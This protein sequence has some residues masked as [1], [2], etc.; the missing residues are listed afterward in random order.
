MARGP[1][2]FFYIIYTFYVFRNAEQD[3]NVLFMINLDIWS[4]TSKKV[5]YIATFN[6]RE[7][8]THLGAGTVHNWFC[9]FLKRCLL[10]K[11]RICLLW[12]QI[13]SF[14]KRALF[15]KVSYVENQT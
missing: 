11:E 14:Q 12:K 5:E 6:L 9:P 4:M 8:A 10:L 7:I 3:A 1:L 15:K 2:V 13:L